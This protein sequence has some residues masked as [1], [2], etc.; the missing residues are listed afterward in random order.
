MPASNYSS[1]GINVTE[2]DKSLSV[3][4]AGVTTIGTVLETSWGA[5][6]KVT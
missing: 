4:A 2:I 5:A 6:F 3:E 1:P